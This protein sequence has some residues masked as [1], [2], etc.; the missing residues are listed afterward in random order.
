MLP[1]KRFIND[2]R[3]FRSSLLSQNQ[4]KL[5]LASQLTL[6]FIFL[7]FF[8]E[9][10]GQQHKL[11]PTDNWS[12][13]YIQRLQNRGFLKELNPTRI[14][15]SRSE[16][17]AALA[18]L[19]DTELSNTESRWVER[20]RN[21]FDVVSS[22]TVRT[23]DDF[24]YGLQLEGG[25]SASN[26]DSLMPMRDL[27][28]KGFIYPN[29]TLTGYMEKGNFIAHM[30]IHHDL[31][32]DQDP[33]GLDATRRLYIRSQDAYLGFANDYLQIYLGRFQNHWAPYGRSSTILSDNARSFDQINIT[34]GNEVFSFRS[35]L[36]EL[37]NISARGVYHGFNPVVGARQR[38]L[39]AHRFDWRIV[40]NIRLTF[41]ES[42]LYS[43]PSS[44]VSLKYLN[45][46]HSLVFV[47]ANKPQNNE[48]NILIGGALWMQFMNNLTI[49]TQFMLDDLDVESDNERT[50]F[51]WFT[52]IDIANV[53]SNVDIGVETEAVAYQ[54]YNPEQ[55]EG[56][57]LYLKR[58]L[59]TQFNDY[60][61]TSLFSNI[62]SGD[63]RIT[64]KLSFLWQGEQEINQPLVKRNPDGTLLDVILT[65]LPEKRIRPGLELFYK[66][67][68]ALTLSLDLGFMMAD[69]LQH[70]SGNS[71]S[72]LNGMLEIKW[73]LF[74]V[75]SQ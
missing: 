37:D 62:Y 61:Y 1:E 19:E 72:G 26:S 44:S 24:T 15:Y 70:I 6:L 52:S 11:V 41:F 68:E 63:L 69:D 43:G 59:A 2:G 31:F 39:A 65:G 55:A 10:K 3:Y 30:G 71:E 74:D 17:K 50:T 49:Q 64:P 25:F 66:P 23:S 54:T 75:H 16:I 38:Y 14:P 56:R 48:G 40:P 5:L 42:V 46:L 36:G 21:Y 8:E 13:D 29:G 4:I 28:S 33:I 58:G 12:Y 18:A 34:F 20:L 47:L 7:S 27:D 32:Y 45:P 60:I 22:D 35:L 67:V 57:Y 9:A 73:K 51:S 53:F